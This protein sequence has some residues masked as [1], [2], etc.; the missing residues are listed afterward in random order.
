MEISSDLAAEYANLV[1]IAH[2]PS[3]LVFDF[4]HLLPGGGHAQ[5]SSRIIMSPL[6]AKLFHRALTENLSKYEAVFG[7]IELPGDS[8]LADQLFRQKPPSDEPPDSDTESE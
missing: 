1:R 2:T 7:K 4:A 8:S 5:V 3:E 6:A